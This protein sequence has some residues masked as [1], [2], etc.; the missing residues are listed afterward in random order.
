MRIFVVVM[1]LLLAASTFAQTPTPAPA[2]SGPILIFGAMAH[3]GNGQV[4]ANSVI[5]F[6]KGVLT[7][8]GDAT[9][10]RID[11]NQYRKILDATGQHV[12]PGFLGLHTRVG[13]VE[14]DAVRATNDVAETGTY[15]PNA[16]ALVAYNTDSEVIP[17][18]RTNGILLAQIVPEGGTISGTS[19]IVQLDAWNWEDAAVRADEGVYLNWPAMRTMGGFETGNPEMRKNER[20][21]VQIQDL[22]RYLNEAKAYAEMTAPTVK[23]L[24]F[25]GLK[26]LFNGSQ[27]LYIRVDQARPMQEAVQMAEQ[28]GITPILVGANDAPLILDFLKQHQVT[29][30][31]R[32][33]QRLPASDDEAVAQAFQLP[34]QLHQAGIPFVFSGQGGWRQRNLPFQ[35]G[36]AVGFGLPYESAVTALT[37]TPARV[38][39]LDK[40][41]GTLEQGKSATLFIS[42][43]DAL[44]MRTCRVVAAFIDG[45]ELN[46]ENRHKALARKF[47][48]KY[49]N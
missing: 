32:E 2:Q 11:R 13:L 19:S 41:Y 47:G 27:K 17:T 16:R 35:A 14:I 30:V 18:I 12:Y 4:I 6:D 25:E 40:R 36:Q 26:G 39:G 24:R 5:A 43:G 48:G 37:S 28:L 3:L 29:V 15:N 23:N 10:I 38:A 1:V 9:N 44:D 20:Y 22:K 34:S 21:E 45:R 8:V 7:L 42:E 31:L 33:T 46:L 49:K